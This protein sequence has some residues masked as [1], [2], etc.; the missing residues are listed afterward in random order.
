[1]LVA[2]IGGLIWTVGHWKF[3]GA[4][5]YPSRPI[6]IVVPYPAGGPT[7]TVARIMAERMKAALGQSVIIENVT[8]AGGSIGVGR[9]AR[10]APDGYT[11]SIGHN[12]THVINAVTQNLNYDVVKD[13]APVAL[14]ADTPIWIVAKKALPANDFKEFL[15]WLKASDGKATAGTVGVGGPNDIAGTFFKKQT[16]TAFQF[17]PYR[18]GAPLL[19]DLLAGQIDFTFGQAAT[20]L[21][22]VRN[23]QL[24]AYGVLTAKRWWAAPDVP[25]LS[26]LGVQGLEASFWHGMWVPKDT[27]QEIVN[28]LNAAVVET[29]ADPTVKQRLT[30]VGQDIFPREHQS[31]SALAAKQRA[32]IEKWWPIIKAAGIKPE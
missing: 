25:T 24:K 15:A 20:Y 16:G 8:G 23:G 31:A 32:E 22:F 29:L 11:I 6:T 5:T 28:K 30:D 1:M 21:N 19:Q 2:A 3:C 7:D 27:P 17:V 26:E 14:I 4:Q 9:V 13:F 10:A 18:G 12:Q